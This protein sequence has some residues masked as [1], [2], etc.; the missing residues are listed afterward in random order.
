LN[1]NT[2]ISGE[3][4]DLIERYLLRSM[5]PDEMHEFAL[6]LTQDTTLHAKVEEVRL[7]M[8]GVSEAV[9]EE[10]LNGY[11]SELPAVDKGEAPGKIAWLNRLLVAAAGIVVVA[12]GAW[13]LLGR[14]SEEEKIFAAHYKPD[15]GLISAMSTS[16]NYAFDRAMVDYKTGFYDTAILSWEGLL[17]TKPDNDTLNYFI[18]SAWLAEDESE[19][20]IPYFQKVIEVPDSYFLKDAYWYLGLALVKENRKKEA[21]PYIEKAEHEQKEALLL[22]LKK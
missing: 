3:E 17:S 7:L 22:K 18:G 20:A 8:L 12:V 9:V 16:D 6:T 15:P 21:I 10:K 5:S 14:P 13:L 1:T 11:H 2:N 19:K 4:L